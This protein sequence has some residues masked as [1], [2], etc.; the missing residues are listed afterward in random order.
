MP[1]QTQGVDKLRIQLNIKI[2]LQTDDT[3]QFNNVLKKLK[4]QSM[5]QMTLKKYHPQ[6]L[7][8]KTS[9]NKFK[10]MN[11][12]LY[13]ILISFCNREFQKSKYNS[14][15][16]IVWK[17]WLINLNIM[18]QNKYSHIHSKFEFQND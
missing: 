4:K 16:Q 10:H 9:N 13:V 14:M 5:I 15:Q 11:M 18:G 6:I 12:K 7:D 8:N 2:K 3:F 1:N 17:F